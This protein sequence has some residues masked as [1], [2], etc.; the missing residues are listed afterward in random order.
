MWV[1]V[2]GVTLITDNNAMSGKLLRQNFVFRNSR[3][4]LLFLILST[5]ISCDIGKP[6]R[7]L[8][9]VSENLV[10][11]ISTSSPT[12]YRLPAHIPTQDTFR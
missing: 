12:N 11:N 1:D 2:R 7:Q 10:T 5:L 4:T 8:V 3:A 6:L 9:V